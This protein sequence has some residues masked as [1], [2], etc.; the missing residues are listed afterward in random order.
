MPEKRRI[1]EQQPE[2]EDPSAVEVPSIS[3]LELF[4]RR[5]ND[6]FNEPPGPRNPSL[7]IKI[8]EA[9]LNNPESSTLPLDIIW[10]LIKDVPPQ[11]TLEPLKNRWG[12]METIQT[13]VE[14]LRQ[15]LHPE[16]Q[17]SETSEYL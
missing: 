13:E 7:L 4:L 3:V 17:E 14:N 12:S 6:A 11:P 16:D 2:R 15:V 5:M 9:L 10:S 1:S 8:A